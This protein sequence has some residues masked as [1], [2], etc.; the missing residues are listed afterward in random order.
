MSPFVKTPFA[1]IDF[2]PAV[3]VA[4]N[5]SSWKVK[6]LTAPACDYYFRKGTPYAAG[7][8]GR[9]WC[10]YTHQPGAGLEGI[11]RPVLV[12]EISLK[13]KQAPGPGKSK[14]TE[15]EA[16]MAEACALEQFQ[17]TIGPLDVL[18]ND[19]ET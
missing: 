10:A 19:M 6:R 4:N 15:L 2:L 9:T 1:P 3:P 16:A 13:H 5:G 8:F 18:E 11:G 14:P 12:K 17:P 7:T